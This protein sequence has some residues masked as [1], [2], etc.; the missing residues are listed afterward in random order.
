MVNLINKHVG[1]KMMASI[2]P[3]EMNGKVDSRLVNF[4]EKVSDG[5]HVAQEKVAD[6]SKYVTE[7]IKAHPVRSTLIAGGVCYLLGRLMK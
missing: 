3:R 1:V 7:Y 4:A 2:N 5:A 6:V